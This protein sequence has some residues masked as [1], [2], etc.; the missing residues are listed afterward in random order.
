MRPR[1]L[2]AGI[3]NIFLSDDGF[4]VEVIK[5]LEG[6]DL[7]PWVQIAGSSKVKDGEMSDALARNQL[8]MLVDIGTCPSASRFT[9]CPK[10]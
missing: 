6:A 2:V 10:A 4:G 9:H 5:E 1:V 7:P 8:Q 3:G